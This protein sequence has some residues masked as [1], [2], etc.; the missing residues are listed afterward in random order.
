MKNRGLHFITAG[1][2]PYHQK[3]EP[4]KIAKKYDLLDK[5]FIES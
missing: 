5:G 4:K 3:T 1:K 2:M